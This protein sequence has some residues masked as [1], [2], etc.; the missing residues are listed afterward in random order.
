MVAET[1]EEVIEDAEAPVHT[2]E[3]EEEDPGL[4]PTEEDLPP[5]TMGEEITEA[6]AEACL[7]GEENIP[8][9][10]TELINEK[11]ESLNV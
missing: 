5:P 10:D 8:P 2:T 9:E 7:P 3:E 11:N 1:G 4:Q 6:G